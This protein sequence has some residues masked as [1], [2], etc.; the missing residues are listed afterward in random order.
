MGEPSVT[1]LQRSAFRVLDRLLHGEHLAA[2][3]ADFEAVAS[4]QARP[5]WVRGATGPSGTRDEALTYAIQRM[6]A[7]VGGAAH[8]AQ[9]AATY[10]ATVDAFD[11][12]GAYARN[13]REDSTCAQ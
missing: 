6:A 1:E 13:R 4:V 7:V 10:A 9:T 2:A 3:L 11:H 8:C 12:P 5:L